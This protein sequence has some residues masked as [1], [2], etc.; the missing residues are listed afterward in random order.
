MKRKMLLAAGLALALAGSLGYAACPSTVNTVVQ[1]GVIDAAG[2]S[3]VNIEG[4]KASYFASLGTNT[5]A[6]TPTDV[7]ILTGSATKTIKVTRVTI[8]VQATASGAVEY[9]LVKRSGGTQSAV[10]TAFAVGTHGGPMDSS[11]VAS[12]VIAAGLAGVYTGNP[13]SVGTAV[14]IVQTWTPT[15]LANAGQTFEYRC[16]VPS[17]CI[18]LRGTSQVLAVNGAAHTLLTGE[19]FGV[20]FEWTEE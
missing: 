15:L 16:S 9:D 5:P 19:K 8:T 20:S 12:T 10:N 2:A 17:K 1:P 13:A 6:A 3:Q 14:G 11:D 4:C 18:T 7:A